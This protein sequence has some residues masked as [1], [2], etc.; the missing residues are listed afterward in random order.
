MRVDSGKQVV[1]GVTAAALALLS[2]ARTFSGAGEWVVGEPRSPPPIHRAGE[3][4]PWLVQQKF[5]ADFEVQ[6]TGNHRVGGKF[7]LLAEDS[8]FLSVHLVY[9]ALAAAVSIGVDL[10]FMMLS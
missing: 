6:A 8:I 4:E 1:V 2:G 7:V 10:I 9:T 5:T 3:R